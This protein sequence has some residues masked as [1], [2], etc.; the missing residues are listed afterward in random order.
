MLLIPPL[1]QSPKTLGTI[2]EN[3]IQTMITESQAK[4]LNSLIQE[5]RISDFFQTA[6]QFGVETI[7]MQIFQKEFIFGVLRFDYYERIQ[8]YVNSIT[9]SDYYNQYRMKTE[10][11][12]LEGQSSKIEL[13]VDVISIFCRFFKLHTEINLGVEIVEKSDMSIRY[14]FF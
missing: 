12:L 4:E 3:H 14:F 8:T 10:L 1:S 9:K 11:I 7:E 6:K 13:V 2:I 5:I